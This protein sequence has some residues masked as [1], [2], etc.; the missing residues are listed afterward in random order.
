MLHSSS[1][2]SVSRPC[3]MPGKPCAT[4]SGV[5]KVSGSADRSYCP[6][7]ALWSLAFRGSVAYL[8]LPASLPFARP[9]RIVPGFPPTLAFEVLYFKLGLYSLSRAWLM[10]PGFGKEILF[11]VSYDVFAAEALW[12]ATCG[13]MLCGF[14]FAWG[15]RFG[16]LRFLVSY[17]AFCKSLQVRGFT[18][19]SGLR[20]C[21][22]MRRCSGFSFRVWFSDSASGLV[23]VRV[24][25]QV[26][27][28]RVFCWYGFVVQICWPALCQVSLA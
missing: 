7:L 1:V 4:V 3:F 6:R 2:G 27:L 5:F 24:S 16:F 26:S 10:S 9:V 15:L 11:C 13:F 25:V 21:P 28:V 14:T 23:Q 19:G 22:G 20:F 17:W 8:S 18:L 12:F